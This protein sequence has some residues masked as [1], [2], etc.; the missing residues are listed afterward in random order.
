MFEPER[1]RR[2]K[3]FGQSLDSS[4]SFVAG[5]R[6]HAAS[7]AR[8]SDQFAGNSGSHLFAQEIFRS[9]GIPSVFPSEEN[10]LCGHTASESPRNWSDI[11]AASPDVSSIRGNLSYDLRQSSGVANH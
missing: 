5:Q 4:Q 7:L 10:S 9:S 2:T 1:D 8:I 11:R 6:I 3:Y